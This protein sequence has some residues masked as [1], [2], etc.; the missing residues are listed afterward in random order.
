[1]KKFFLAWAISAAIMWVMGSIYLKVIV[2]LY[3]DWQE[4]GEDF[5]SLVIILKSLLVLPVSLLMTYMYPK[6][7]QGGYPLFE[8]L[9]FGVMVGL[10]IS[11]PFNTLSYYPSIWTALL[12][13]PWRMMEQGL[14]GIAIALVY[15]SFIPAKFA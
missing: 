1:M 15:G 13:I 8:G 5:G 7:Y 3:G 14:M 2:S 9:R 6:G 10:L 12:D 11:I 4:S